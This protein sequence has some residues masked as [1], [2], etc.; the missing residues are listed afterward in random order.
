MIKIIAI[1]CLLVLSGCAKQPIITTP[2][3][4]KIPV[5]VP[6]KTPIIPAPAWPTSELR[7]GDSIFRQVQLILAELQIRKGYEAQ[8]EAAIKSCQ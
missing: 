4:V 7:A 6:C 2:V 3:E 5:S 8:L 1:I